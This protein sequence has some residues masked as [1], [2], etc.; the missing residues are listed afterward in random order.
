[1]PEV[2]DR[3][4]SPEIQRYNPFAPITFA[5]L[6]QG[7]FM[8][9]LIFFWIA[10]IV[11]AACSTKV[12]LNAPYKS[13][14]VV[15]GLLD[16]KADTQ[17][18]KI[19]KTFLGEGNNLDYAM[20]RDSSEYK[21]EEFSKLAVEEYEGDDLVQTF[22]LQ[23]LE[24]SNKEMNGI[25]FAPEQTVYYFKTPNNGLDETHSYRL[26]VEF[27]DRPAVYA[28]TT[29]VATSGM[30]FTQPQAVAGG[31]P[32][33]TI[34]LVSSYNATTGPNYNE[35]ALIKW[36][37][38][39]NSSSF[40]AGIVFHYSELR[41]DGTEVP[42]S[43]FYNLGDPTTNQVNVGGEL[44]LKFGGESF[45]NF[46]STQIPTSPDIIRRKIGFF[47]GTTTRCFDLKVFAANEELTRYLD[48]NAP[49]T[50]LIQERPTITNIENG[51]GLFASRSTIT[52]KNVP[53]TNSNGAANSRSNLEALINSSYTQGLNFCDPNPNGDYACP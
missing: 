19:N 34:S 30:R 12:E 7:L 46:L 50:G 45:F 39:N 20:V 48:A 36:S 13:T 35:N 5:Q 25:F 24:V 1:M 14:T 42:R 44:Q 9:K 40:T 52:L 27:F 11:V 29:L 2:L 28:T 15:F 8:K 18:I 47:D 4:E 53:L 21:W 32:T 41:A 43:I 23:A 10:A 3:Q 49:V 33:T 22:N 26:V 38:P 16:S 6:T 17:W 37:K 51:I 31:D